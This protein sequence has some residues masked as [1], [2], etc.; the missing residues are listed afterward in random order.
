MSIGYSASRSAL[1]LIAIGMFGALAPQAIEARELHTFQRQQLGNEFFAEGA[2]FGDL[3]RDGKADI[4]A[5][6]FWFEGPTFEKRHEY[7]PPKPFD[8][9]GYS[10]NFFAYT[11]D[12]NADGWNDILIIGFPGRDASWFENPQGADKHWTRHV[13]MKTV[14]NESPTFTDITGDGK[15]EIVCSVGGFFGYADWDTKTAAEPWPFHP[16]SD[17]SAGGNFTHGLGVGDV[18]GDGKLDLLEKNGWWEQPA[19][20]DGNPR[21]TKHNFKFAEGGGA[22]MYAYDV[23]GDKRNDVITSLN[24]HGYGL[25]WWKQVKTD[26]EPD[27]EKHVITGNSPS[28]N[29]YGV[30]FSELHAVDL[31]DIDGDGLKDIVTGKRWWAHGPGGDDKRGSPAVIYWFQLARDNDGKVDWIPHLIDDNSGVGTQVVAGDF[32]GDK[33][34]DVVVGNKKGFFAHTQVVKDVPEE[35][36]KQAQPR[37]RREMSHGLSPQEAAEAMTVPAGFTVKLFAGEPDVQQPIAMALDDRGRLWVAEAFSYPTR[38]P[39]NEAKDRILIFEDADGDGKFDKRT[40]FAD[41]LNLVSGL[42]VGF[43]GVWVGAAPQFLFIPDANGDDKPDGPPQVLL[44]GWGYQ[45]TH[46]TLNSFIWGPDGWM[47]GCHGVFTFSNVGK[48]G[49]SDADRKKINAGIWRYHPTRHEFEVF[50][51]GTSNP[52]GVD[53]NDRGQ[54]FATACVIPHLYHIIQGGRYQRQAGTHHNPYIFDDIKTIARHRHWV[55]NQ[56]NDADRAKSDG[57]GGG[58]AHAGAMIYLGGSWPESYRNQLFMNNIHGARLNEDLLTAEGSGY[59]GDAAPDF[60]FTNDSWSQIIYLTYGPDGQVYMID[61]Y[62]KNQCHHGNVQGHDRTNGR[63]F[64][65]VYGQP[66]PVSV[67]LKK[68]SDAELVALH[69]HANE[70]YARHSRRVLQERAAAKKLQPETA[71]QVRKLLAESKVPA[72]Q[73]RLLWILHG[74][75]GLTENDALGLLGHANPDVRAWTIQ[76]ACEEGKPTAT[77][78]AKFASLAAQDPSSVVRLYL[79]A[80]LQQLPVDKR[81][82]I[83]EALVAH[84]EDG[85]DH[86]LPLM[87]WYGI[88]PLVA[89]DPSRAMRLAQSSKIPTV[90]RFIVRRAAFDDGAYEALFT[91]LAKAPADQQAWMLGEIVSALK[92]RDQVKMPASWKAAYDQLIAQGSDEAKQQAEFIAVKFG[93]QRVFSQ[94]RKT[95]ADRKADLGRRRLA[96]DS[97]L[98]GKDGELPAVLQKLLDDGTIRTATINALG[99]F[100]N[101]QTPATLLAAYGKLSTEDK[102]AAIAVLSSR[103]AYVLALLDSMEQGRVPRADLTAFTVRQISRFKD[104]RVTK[105]LNE[106]WGTLR[107]TSADKVAELA[108]YKALLKPAQLTDANL[109]HG[110]ELF[111]KTCGTCHTLFNAGKNIGPDITGSNRANLDYLLE[112]L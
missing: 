92:L 29:P 32:S 103:P 20:L 69:T 4:I 46:E 22:Q 72:Q 45:D 49:A 81:W 75:G 62:D 30:V 89:A 101:A 9:H 88:E 99:A 94:L 98:A 15:P 109:P 85:N 35:A 7:Y 6:P 78:L 76:L 59:I 2:T 86:N 42:Q 107:E 12:F 68:L 112:N 66:K 70:W 47:Y 64:K 38:V 63:I 55:G 25:V 73:L 74:I 104:E 8:P 27:F 14:D 1:G 67:D 21:W 13:V 34:P 91:A 87:N 33:R 54:S 57:I 93:D 16:I 106:V 44:D 100:D 83:A 51:E 65:I 110:R 111:N 40:V 90:Q 28:D 18:N 95:L 53:F 43:G 84:A 52:W 24:A 48:P 37:K 80:A 17:Q 60:C 102:Q 97:L 108:K 26:G 36:W 58:H 105:R 31:I 23:D 71:A 10:D 79:T 56:W 11:Q 82:S 19:K 77:V 39:E 3:N 41:K 5:G 96:L 61:W 50:A